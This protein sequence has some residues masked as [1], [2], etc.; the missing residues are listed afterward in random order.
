LAQLEACRR[1]AAIHIVGPDNLID[2]PVSDYVVH[3]ALVSSLFQPDQTTIANVA[4]LP[5]PMVCDEPVLLE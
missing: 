5:V 1:I 2:G 4:P 3:P